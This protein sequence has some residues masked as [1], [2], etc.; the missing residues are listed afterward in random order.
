MYFLKPP[1]SLKT[2][3][4]SPALLC[5]AGFSGN[6]LPTPTAA[7]SSFTLLLFQRAVVDFIAAAVLCIILRRNRRKTVSDVSCSGE[8]RTAG[9]GLKR[10]ERRNW[11]VE[12]KCRVFK[13]NHHSCFVLPAAKAIVIVEAVFKDVGTHLTPYLF[14]KAGVRKQIL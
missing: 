11:R 8:N 13:N 6:T 1:L 14:V 5:L 9:T 12:V 10:A 4:L 2:P 3:A 7:R